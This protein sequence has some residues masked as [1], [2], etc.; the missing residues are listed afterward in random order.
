MEDFLKN[1]V[2]CFVMWCIDV[3]VSIMVFYIGGVG[4]GWSLLKY[5]CSDVG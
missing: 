3:I 5:I 1:I 4:F 2:V